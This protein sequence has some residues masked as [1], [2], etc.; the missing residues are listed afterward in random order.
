MK[1]IPQSDLRN[2]LSAALLRVKAGE[3]LRIT[4]CGQD[5]ADL[6]PIAEAPVWSAGARARALIS[7]AQADLGLAAELDRAFPDTTDQ[8]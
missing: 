7:R 2:D 5:V 4:V 3:P 8:L 6:M 1:R